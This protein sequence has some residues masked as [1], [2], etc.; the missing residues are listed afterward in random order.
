[1]T[2]AVGNR[3]DGLWFETLSRLSGHGVVC[4]TIYIHIPKAKRTKLE[5]SGK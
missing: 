3:L 4:M 5:P 1:V 2:V